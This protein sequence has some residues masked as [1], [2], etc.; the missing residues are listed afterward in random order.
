MPKTVRIFI[1]STFRDMHAER[2]VLT[3]EVLPRLREKA[4]PL[5]LF[6]REVDLRWGL[7]DEQASRGQVL[8]LCLDGI[9][10]CRPYFLC[11]LGKRYGWVPPPDVLRADQYERALTCTD[12]L[13]E[14][15]VRLLRGHYLPLD[16]A[17]RTLVLDREKLFTLSC[18]ESHLIQSRLQSILARTGLD[19]ARQSITEQ[20]IRYAVLDKGAPRWISQLGER[21]RGG[22]ESGTLDEAGAAMLRKYYRRSS[23]EQVWRLVHGDDEADPEALARAL[24]PLGRHPVMHG[25][26]Y[27]RGDVGEDHPDY[28]ENVPEAKRRQGEL[29][30]EIRRS[31]EPVVVR[32]YH[33]SWR[34]ERSKKGLQPICDLEAFSQMVFEDLW[35]HIQD[36]TELRAVASRPPSP[37]ESE[38]RHHEL[39]AESRTFNFRGRTRALGHLERLVDRVLAP[40][41]SDMRAE[42]PLVFV[43]GTAGSGKSALLAQLCAQQAQRHTERLILARFIGA[44]RRSALSRDLLVDL[45]AQVADELGERPDLPSHP[46]DLRRLL[47]ELLGRLGRP[48]LLVL[49]ALDQLDASAGDPDMSWL[50]KSLPPGVC[51]LFSVAD[52]PGA[53]RETLHALRDRVPGAAELQLDA[54]SLD[55]RREII[56]TYLAL[57][58]KRLPPELRDTVASKREADHPL[59]LAVALEELRLF[60][61]HEEL[62]TFISERLPD[63]VVEVF[64]L[65]LSRLEAELGQRHQGLDE[66]QLFERFM[67]LLATGRGGMSEEDLRSQLGRWKERATMGPAQARLSDFLWADLRRSVRSFIVERGEVYSFFHRQLQ[68]A[69]TRRYLGVAESRATAHRD[70]ADYFESRGN[71]YRPTVEDLPYHL[72]QSAIEEGTESPEWV[73]VAD[74]LTSLDF[75]EAKARMRLVQE[76]CDDCAMVRSAA[77]RA[78]P[79]VAALVG[80]L[81]RA[82]AR[83]ITTLGLHHQLLF[84]QLLPELEARAA[85]RELAREWAS[86]RRTPHFGLARQREISAE[87]WRDIR[88]LELPV[89]TKPLG[90]LLVSP[91]GN[92]AVFLLSRPR[93]LVED[94]VQS[95]AHELGRKSEWGGAWLMR[96]GRDR[97]GRYSW[98]REEVPGTALAGE[99]QS[100][101]PSGENLLELLKQLH[102]GYRE[103]CQAEGSD[104]NSETRSKAW[105]ELLAKQPGII[106]LCPLPGSNAVAFATRGGLVGLAWRDGRSSSVLTPH[107]K[108]IVNCG[109]M[110]SDLI[111]LGASFDV[112]LWD[113]TA[114]AEHGHTATD[115]VPVRRTRLSSSGTHLCLQLAA[116]RESQPSGSLL[117]A[118]WD[119]MIRRTAGT[120]FPFVLAQAESGDIVPLGDQLFQM[121]DVNK[122]GRVWTARRQRA[123]MTFESEG[124]EL[125]RAPALGTVVADH[126]ISP[127]G[128]YVFLFFEGTRGMLL[129]D[130]DKGRHQQLDAGGEVRRMHNEDT[131]DGRFASYVQAGRVVGEVRKRI[132]YSHDGREALHFAYKQGLRRI[133]LRKL[134]MK[135]L[136]PLPFAGPTAGEAYEAVQCYAYGLKRKSWLVGTEKCLREIRGRKLR[137]L[138]EGSTVVCGTLPHTGAIWAVGHHGELRLM[139]K[140]DRVHELPDYVALVPELTPSR[141]H[142]LCV[143][144]NG[145]L[146]VFDGTGATPVLSYGLEGSPPKV[147]GTN[148]GIT[149]SY[150]DGSSARYTIRGLRRW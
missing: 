89:S 95:M 82:L 126:S 33:C 91:E 21:V 74:L 121:L 46:P 15:E 47:L 18:G 1:S 124:R 123:L 41:T 52:I 87:L 16:E 40:S 102:P 108:G 127:D 79:E 144:A 63:T 129:V 134:A 7:T 62:E 9:E 147:F 99:H 118:D 97:L 120:G 117:A 145:R 83:N 32:V 2:D 104:D 10:E 67:T 14:E 139:D 8:E 24:A 116:Q 125:A 61:R 92:E 12:L 48:C 31:P 143:T 149:L 54:L 93:G 42:P 6:I 128:R 66:S 146:L 101:N 84:T 133:L 50:P 44:S 45:C 35:E 140:N 5:G 68:Q 75:L 142:L 72:T 73:R 65:L 106:G 55:E 60:A 51:A 138:M 86:K 103:S 25:F 26:F 88:K 119:N 37:L 112:Y 29:V 113:L 85:T 59:Y 30:A 36:N 19:R 77:G 64:D 122:R 136:P 148:N 39:F 135:P 69:V 111:T 137:T 141:R 107:T 56:E 4:E 53:A 132:V 20:E 57:F 23:G 130:L 76:L 150:S 58:N 114:L 28:L 70:V 43:S 11:L 100:A 105:S 3:R 38:L 131:E 109:V 96:L 81:E 115:R 94:V 71:T 49:D 78:P 90:P 34:P 17:G 13:S 27:V 22:L 98:T 110:G 80:A